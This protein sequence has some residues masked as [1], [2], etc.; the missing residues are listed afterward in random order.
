[1]TEVSRQVPG[2]ASLPFT[3]A[4][5][6]AVRRHRAALPAG[7]SREWAAAYPDLAGAVLDAYRRMLRQRAGLEDQ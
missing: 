5:R 6:L 7:D 3:E 1:M 4:G 2:I